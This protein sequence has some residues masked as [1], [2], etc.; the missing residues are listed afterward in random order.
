M[1]CYQLYNHSHDEEIGNSTKKTMEIFSFRYPV[2][3]AD[4]GKI[5]DFPC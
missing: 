4:E 3:N 1:S 2:R 5:R